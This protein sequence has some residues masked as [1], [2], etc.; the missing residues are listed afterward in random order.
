MNFIKNREVK[1]VF[2]N[3]GAHWYYL[4]TGLEK[5]SDETILEVSFEYFVAYIFC[6]CHFN[7]FDRAKMNH[8]KGETVR[9][10]DF[11]PFE[12]STTSSIFQI[13]TFE[14]RNAVKMSGNPKRKIEVG[15]RCA[16]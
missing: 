16:G 3:T 1:P 2:A 4:N 10:E 7:F 9:I 8:Q 14:Q 11:E 13:R 5:N 6:R 12:S 15:L